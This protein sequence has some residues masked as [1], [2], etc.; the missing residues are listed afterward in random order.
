[1]RPSISYNFFVVLEQC[2][3]DALPDTR[4]DAFMSQQESQSGLQA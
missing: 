4:N 2:G 3:P 1:M